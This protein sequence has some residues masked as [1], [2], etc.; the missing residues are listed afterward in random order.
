MQVNISGVE[1][2]LRQHCGMISGSALFSRKNNGFTSLLFLN[3]QM[4]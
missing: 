4:K 3:V 1:E 2:I